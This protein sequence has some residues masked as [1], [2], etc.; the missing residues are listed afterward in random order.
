[1]VT[2]DL[3]PRFF[4]LPPLRWIE[5][6]VVAVTRRLADPHHGT[7]LGIAPELA[8]MQIAAMSREDGRMKS[9]EKKN[10]SGKKIKEGMRNGAV[11]IKIG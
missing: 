2:V 11:Q 5:D 4:L 10:G 6:S 7:T 8:L 1:V 3:L 9:E